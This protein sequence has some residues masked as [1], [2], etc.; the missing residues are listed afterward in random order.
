MLAIR[1]G[2]LLFAYAA[3]GVKFIPLP[4]YHSYGD[5][6]YGV[7]FPRLAGLKLQ[8]MQHIHYRHNL[9]GPSLHS[10]IP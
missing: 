9:S 2:A 4:R 10:S 1:Y 6:K 3:L 8:Y 7:A 5:Y